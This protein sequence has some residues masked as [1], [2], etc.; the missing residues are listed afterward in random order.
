MSNIEIERISEDKLSCEFWRFRADTGIIG[1]D[2]VYVRLNF[3][4]RSSRPTIRHKF[5]Y[6]VKDRFCMD[7]Q[8]SYNS[9]IEA[10]DVP[11]PADVCE[12]AKSKVE[13]VM[14]GADCTPLTGGKYVE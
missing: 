13:F 7:D 2:R 9:G 14:V 8:R 5:K 1:G 6:E 11:L 12:E 4:G 3:Y 10:A